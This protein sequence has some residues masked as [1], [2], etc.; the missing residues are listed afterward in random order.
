MEEKRMINQNEKRSY[1][2]PSM[3]VVELQSGVVMQA[4]SATTAPYNMTLQQYVID[5]W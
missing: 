5:S 1:E 3:R 4:M 2:R